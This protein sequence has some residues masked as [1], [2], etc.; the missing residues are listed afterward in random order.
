[1]IALR[2]TPPLPA[3]RDDDAVDLL[4]ACHERI[5]RFS[6][7]SV[8]LGSSDGQAAPAAEVGDVARTLIHY[9]TRALPL[10]AEDEDRSLAPRLRSAATN[11]GQLAV[12]D[13]V[14]RMSIEHG[15]LDS[16]IGDLA[17]FWTRLAARPDELGAMA[18]DLQ[19]AAATMDALWS[20]HLAAE[21]SIVFPAARA[22]LP[23]A[24]LDAILG[25]MRRR[26][27]AV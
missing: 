14:A 1:M 12:V 9:F 2:R 17:R 26:R 27:A 4:R 24:E 22:L 11:A 6:A 23:G 7:L 13:A 16:A 8:R 18:P 20:G 21:E 3:V 19:P 5:R 15:P 25:E 10:H